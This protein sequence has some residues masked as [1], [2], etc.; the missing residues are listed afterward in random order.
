MSES[1]EAVEFD[2]N[3]VGGRAISFVGKLFKDVPKEE[4]A[5]LA[6]FIC[7]QAVT[8]GA[9]NVYEGIGIYEA[10]KLAYIEACEDVM[11]EECDDCCGCGCESKG[12]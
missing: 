2:F 11:N 9:Y 10:S 3:K 5:R 7:F 12:E 4:R 6:D 8:Q 1:K